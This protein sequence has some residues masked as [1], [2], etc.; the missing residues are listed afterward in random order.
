MA[1]APKQGRRINYELRAVDGSHPITLL[2]FRSIEQVMK[3]APTTADSMLSIW[4]VPE[5]G[6]NASLIAVKNKG[7]KKWILIDAARGGS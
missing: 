5:S 4:A 2:S 3:A 6:G 1:T 7:D